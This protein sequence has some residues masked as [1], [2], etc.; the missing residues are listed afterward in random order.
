MNGCG[1]HSCVIAPPKGM[2]TNG[3]CRCDERA[4][5][6]GARQLR[7]RVRVLEG[8]RNSWRRIAWRLE[9]ELRK[10]DPDMAKAIIENVPQE[11]P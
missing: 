3:G 8:H 10:H 7:E 2:G 4:L 1:D 11:K 6:L 9:E 5:R